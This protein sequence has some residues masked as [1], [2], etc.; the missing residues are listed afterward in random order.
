M[1]AGK[2][3]AAAMDTKMRLLA[4]ACAVA[5]V[6]L[7]ASGALAA[8]P[9]TPAPAA[10]A[11]ETSPEVVV[12]ANKHAQSTYKV[13][14]AVSVVSSKTLQTAGLNTLTD[15]SEFVPGLSSYSR[16]ATGTNQ[17]IL[18]G[19]TSGSQQTS[20][21]VGIYINDT[22]FVFSIPVGGGA[23]ILQADLDPGLVSS[24]EVLRGPQG[25]LYG[26]ST[27]G[28]LIKYVTKQPNADQFGGSVTA[29]VTDVIKGDTGYTLRGNVNVPVVDD[30][31]A[32]IVSA[33]DR[34]DPGYID[35]TQLHE[36]NVNYTNAYGGS[37]SVGIYPTSNLKI[38]LS[39]IGEKND[40]N[41][42]SSVN[43]NQATLVPIAGDLTQQ[44]G[45]NDYFDTAYQFY[46]GELNWTFGGFTLTSSTSYTD[47]DARVLFDF[48]SL[49]PGFLGSTL[50]TGPQNLHYSAFT[51]ED[52]IASPEN[53]FVQFTGGVYYTHENVNA[54]SSI[55]LYDAGGPPV[56]VPVIS[57]ADTLAR[58]DEI[59]GFGNVVFNLT[60]TWNV[61][62]GAR[63]GQD[64]IHDD[65]YQ[66]GL[67]A[68]TP[69]HQPVLTEGN[70]HASVATYLVSTNWN[71]ASNG[72]LYARAA[73]GYRPG[74]PIEANPLAPPN[75]EIPTHYNSDQVWD[76]ELG[77]KTTWLDG[78]LGANLDLFYIDWYDIQLPFLVN[79]LRELSNGGGAVSKGVEF[80][81]HYIPVTGLTLSAVASYTD[82]R[83]TTP[84][85]LVFGS[86]GDRLPFVPQ[87][88]LTLSADY[89]HPIGPFEGSVGI[90][91]HYQ[92]DI[93]IALSAADP[94]FADLPGFSTVD[95]RAGLQYDR[96][97]LNVYVRNLFDKR[98]YISGNFPGFVPI[99]PLTVGALVSAKF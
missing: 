3:G 24:I 46:D 25:T 60:H 82:A 67:L 79:G 41:A 56:S 99:Q 45:V 53:R 33:F 30:K 36:N 97:A 93:N 50:A 4:G 14:A 90:S 75:V 57:L 70:T 21:T 48:T 8:D 15:L 11:T 31:V 68:G 52:R 43:L 5:P 6:L 38:V 10:A 51:E 98:A 61:T 95:L 94:T 65:V 72:S 20:P 12:T 7:F 44:I 39:A 35:N 16:G 23:S 40:V 42:T 2:K 92:S 96:Y 28:G 73:S 81:G 9:V 80:E 55:N 18:D 91:Y 37:V 19:L 71:F 74:G 88:E 13:A 49:L 34:R 62:L 78:R 1:I 85:P 26:A 54:G 83:L 32:V 47:A 84:A 64:S 69:L 66:S 76:Y 89:A 63:Y 22:P 27:L 77:A 17:F 58:Y 59:A 87:T 29:G 86:T